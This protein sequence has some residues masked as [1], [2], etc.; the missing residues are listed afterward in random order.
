MLF[1][2]GC[3]GRLRKRLRVVLF[4][5]VVANVVHGKPG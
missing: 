2:G 1:E 5:I 4:E 3:T